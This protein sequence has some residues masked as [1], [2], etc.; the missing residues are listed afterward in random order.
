MQTHRWSQSWFPAHRALV[1]QVAVAEPGGPDGPLGRV[2]HV[3]SGQATYFA[4]G[5][6]LVAF[7]AQ[8]LAEGK[9]E[10]PATL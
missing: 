2:E 1:V 6:E 8:L 7:I 9:T 10:P 5:A 3:V 4:S